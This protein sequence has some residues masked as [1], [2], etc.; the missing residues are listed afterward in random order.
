MLSMGHLGSEDQREK[1][2][3]SDLNTAI[4]WKS[5]E[6]AIGI[7]NFS[8]VRDKGAYYVDKSE[9]IGRILEK[10]PRRPSCSQGP[11]ASGNR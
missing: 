2:K 8:E 5:M 3:D 7:Q 9:L 4:D 10:G 6:A 1:G 11:G